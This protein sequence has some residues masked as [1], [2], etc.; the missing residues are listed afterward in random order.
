M[1]MSAGST[2]SAPMTPQ[3]VQ[4]VMSLPRSRAGWL[5]VGSGVFAVVWAFGVSGYVHLPV[6]GSSFFMPMAASIVAVV[7]GLNAVRTQHERSLLLWI[8]LVLT[9]LFTIAGMAFFA[10]EVFVG[11]A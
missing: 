6:P 2:T 3:G 4:A 5:S 9:A 7:A 8:T 10:L 1:T 11:H